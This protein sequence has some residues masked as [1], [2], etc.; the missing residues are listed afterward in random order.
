MGK[1]REKESTVLYPEDTG[2]IATTEEI[3][4]RDEASC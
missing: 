3:L 1:K 4:G 2:F